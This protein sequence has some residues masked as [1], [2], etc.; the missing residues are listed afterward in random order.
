MYLCSAPKRLVSEVA[1]TLAKVS[2]PLSRLS[3]Y[4]ITTTF[5]LNQVRIRSCKYFV[6]RDQLAIAILKAQGRE[7]LSL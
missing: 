3:Q 5:A 6:S 1:E 7:C 2:V 4:D